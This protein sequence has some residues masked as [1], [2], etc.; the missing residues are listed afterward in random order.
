ML[1]DQG[2]D[3]AIDWWQLG[4]ITYQMLTRTSPFQ[5]DDEDDIYDSI[6]SDEPSYPD[7]WSGDAI[8][9]IQKLLQKDPERRLGSITNGADQVMAHAFFCRIN[10]DDLYHKRIPA[11]FVPTVLGGTDISHFVSEFTLSDTQAVMENQEGMLLNILS[12]IFTDS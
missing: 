9:F 4:I 10:W 8:D 2:Y 7:Y 3:F 11:P 5:G 1:L 12:L 6:L